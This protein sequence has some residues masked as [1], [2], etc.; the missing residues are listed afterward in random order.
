[1]DTD[2]ADLMLN[3]SAVRTEHTLS[4][5][6]GGEDTKYYFTTNYLSQEGNVV[7]SKFD[8]VTTRLS[9]DTKVNSW[10]KSGVTMFFYIRSKFSF[11]KW[12]KL[13]KCNSIC[14]YSAFNL[15]SV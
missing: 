13:S 11:T 8:R 7:T 10:L 5:A 1:V 12:I 4:I 2:W 3:N 14:L 6:A 15:S 9:V